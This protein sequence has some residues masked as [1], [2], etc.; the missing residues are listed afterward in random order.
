MVSVYELFGVNGGCTCD[1]NDHD[2]GSGC[3]GIYSSNDGDADDDDHDSSVYKATTHLQ[4][5]KP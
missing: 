5:Y 3:N 1:G 4:Q 2:C